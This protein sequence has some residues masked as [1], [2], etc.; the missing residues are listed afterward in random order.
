MK[1]LTSYAI[2]LSAL[3]IGSTLVSTQ[4]SAQ[5]ELALSEADIRLLDLAFAPLSLTAD[6]SGIPLP[7]RVIASPNAVSKAISRYEGTL[8]RWHQLA[9]ARVDQ[10]AVLASL[11]STPVLEVQQQ[12]LDR[13]NDN[14]LLRQQVERERQ[15]FASGVIAQQRL[16]ISESRLRSSDM[17]VRASEQALRSAGLNDRDLQDLRDGEF[18]LGI[19]YIRAPG[20]GTLAHQYFRTGDYVA[21]NAVVAGLMTGDRAWLSLQMPAR[22]LPALSEQSYLTVAGT[23]QRLTLRQRDFAIDPDTQSV[24]LLAEFEQ[25]GEHTVGQILRV[26]LHPGRE[27]VFIPASA[28]VHEDQQTLVYIRSSQ[29]VEIRALELLPLGDGYQTTAGVSVGEQI[30]VRGAALVKGMQLGLGSDE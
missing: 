10:G 26:L 20:S 23:M 28:V 1:A 17:L 24:E 2:F 29:G 18:D 9:G 11:R 19:T 12:F 21:A 6:Q 13:D 3:L 14:T 15:L 25:S 16:Q 22:L 7:G 5:S 4:S 8:E 30:L 27:T